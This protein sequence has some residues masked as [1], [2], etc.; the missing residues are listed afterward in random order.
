[1]SRHSPIYQFLL[2]SEILSPTGPIAE[3]SA[4]EGMMSPPRRGHGE[5]GARRDG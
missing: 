2:F 4:T 3:V 1:M 5:W